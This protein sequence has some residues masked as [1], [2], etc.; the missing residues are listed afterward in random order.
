MAPHP[1]DM[2]TQDEVKAAVAAA[3]ATGRLG[4]GAR[5]AS[6]ALEEPPKEAVL[7]GDALARRVHLSI[8]PGPAAEVIEAVVDVATGEVVRWDEIGGVRPASLFEDAIRAIAVLKEDPAWL[9]AMRGR[10]ITDV[11]QV[12]IDPWPTGNFGIAMEE[13][14][15]AFRCVSYYRETPASNGY[16]RPIE[17]VLAFVDGGRGQVLEVVDT[18]TVPL[19]P[20]AGS[21]WPEDNQPQREDLRPISITQPSGPSFTV[22]GN[23]VRWQRWSLRVSMDPLEGL[24]LHTVAF[25]GR[26]VLYRASI[27]EMVVPYGDP[28]PMHGWKN[29]FDAGEW[30]LGRMA[31]SLV[32]GCDCLGEIHYFDAVFASEGGDPYTLENAI[33][34]HEEDYGLLWKHQDLNSGRTESRRSRRLVVSFIA[35]VGNY[36]YGF[37]WYFYL[38][39]T[40]QLEV[41]LTGVMQTQALPSGERSPFAAPIAPGLHAPVHQHLFSARLDLDVDGTENEVY[42][43][44]A[45]PLPLGDG[46]PLSNA[47][48]ARAT[49]LETERS[50]QRDVDPARSRHWRIVNPTARNGLG[51]PVAYKLV[52]GPVPTLLAAPTSSVGRRATFATH[53]LWVT[54]YRP[55]ERRAA[56]DYPNQHPGGEGLPRWTAADRPIS[57]TDIV[58]WHTFGV[59]HL[60]RPED[61]PV[62]P[63]EYCGFHLVPVGFFDRNPALDVPP[64]DHCH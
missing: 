8:V 19:P 20:E 23:L 43:V 32:L 64:V 17:G 7:A 47:F 38:D 49:K 57:G 36:E 28:G 39:G 50:A 35:T 33:C 55:D 59:T 34:M 45:E 4:D 37:Y 18:G 44:E 62:M 27:C 2:L 41:K 24:V 13:G 30:G 53:N 42:E 12:Q 31:N 16:A 1:L 9:A 22:D 52:P 40:V 58:L 5:F 56:G 29:A 10:G 14:R 54:P 26:P 6:V 3:R 25:D 61:W 60:P 51:E 11:Q 63:V 46:N 48:V 15:R 21:Y